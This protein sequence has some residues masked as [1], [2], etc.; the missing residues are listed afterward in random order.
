MI[1]LLSFCPKKEHKIKNLILDSG[2]IISGSDIWRFG[3][4]FYTVPEVI[5]EIKD[6]KSKAV[7][8]NF[9]FEIKI[10]S[11][12]PEALKTSLKN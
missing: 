6:S 2:A 12:T 9:P 1:L 10:R 11:P 8:K 3:D 5:D 4:N 7:L